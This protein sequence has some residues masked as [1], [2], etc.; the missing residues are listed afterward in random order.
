MIAV[1]L[2]Y[3]K[4]TPTCTCGVVGLQ[5]SVLYNA[6]V[7]H[8]E[9][10]YVSNAPACAVVRADLERLENGVSDRSR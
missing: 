10:P 2:K 5:A 1:L 7:M 4:A 9:F 6:C 3:A 8:W